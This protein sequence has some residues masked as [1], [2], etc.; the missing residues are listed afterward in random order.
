MRLIK[1]FFA[2]I[3]LF[4]ASPLWSQSRNIP[5]IAPET[6]AEIINN[7]SEPNIVI[8]NTGPVDDIKGA[9]NIGAIEEKKNLK[10]LKKALRKL[11]KD[12]H[13]VYYCGCCPF[14]TCPNLLPADELLKKKGFTNF[15]A[16]DLP[17][18]LKIDWMNKGYPME[19]AT[20]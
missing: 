11:P 6:L 8:F 10:K 20:H 7:N 19:E 5:K 14:A 13:I 4:S 9:I 1:Y 17:D 2:L 18:A 12:T 16:L 15:Q 3:T